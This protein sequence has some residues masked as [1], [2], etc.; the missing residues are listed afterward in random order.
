MN[1][2]G[3]KATVL[4]LLCLSL[5][6][7]A[8]NTHN[9]SYFPYLLPFGD[10]VQTHAKAPGAGYYANFDPYAV[11]LEVRPM[12]DSNGQDITNQARTQHVLIA[13]VYDEKGQPRRDRRVEWMIEGAGHILEVDESGYLS[14]R[15]YK[16]NDK[17]GVSYTSKHENRI[18]RGDKQS[19]NDFM[20]RPGQTWCVLSSAIEGDTHVTVYAPGIADWDKNKVYTTIRWVDAI[21]EFPQPVQKP[22]GSEHVFVTKLA[23]A[24]T[25]QPLAGYRVRY[26]IKDGPAAYFL[27][28]KTQEF[29][30]T[31]DLSGNAEGRITLVRLGEQLPAAGINNVDI[32]V[33]RPPD[34]TAPSGSGI[35]IARGVTSVEW[36]APN[37]VLAYTGPAAALVDEEVTYTATLQNLGK[38]ASEGITLTA[39]VPRGMEFVRSVPP[40]MGNVMGEMLFTLGSLPPGGQPANV[41]LTFKA[42]ELGQTSSV[43]TMRSGGQSDRKEV[44][45][46]IADSKISVAV[47]G[48][49]RVAVGQTVPIN[50]RVTNT[51]GG[52]LNAI[53]LKADLKGGIVEPNSNATTL[54]QPLKNPLGPGQTYTDVLNVV[55]KAKGRAEVQVFATTGTVSSSASHAFDITEPTVSLQVDGPTKKYVGRDATFTIRVT[56]PSDAALNNVMVRNQLPPELDFVTA[57]S[58]Q[59]SGR[60]VVWNLGSL[61]PGQSRDLKLVAR[62][63]EKTPR[64]EQRFVVTSDNAGPANQSLNTEIFGS[65]GLRL[66]MRDLEDPVPVGGKAVYE[67]VI[68]NTGTDEA[69]NVSMQGE[70]AG[71]LAQILEG[72]GP[73]QININANKFGFQAINMKPNETAKYRVIVL[74]GDREMD[75]VFRCILNADV[76]QGP[77]IEDENTRIYIPRPGGANPPPPPPGGVPPGGPF[78]NVSI[79]NGLTPPP[80]NTL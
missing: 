43:L 35:V 40:P 7:S 5:C 76:L 8:C 20:I 51:G 73:S 63:R 57:E 72:A 46:N 15:G 67:I 24:T 13:T 3:R 58:G 61:A 31:S 45:T 28:D 12:K 6:A 9:P 22:A 74:A 10:I 62:C 53:Q 80:A 52:V 65:P 34:P 11:R 60:D 4:L 25:K 26:R 37:V 16:T 1:G 44:V 27:P 78:G 30:A 68:T 19:Q 54:S 56:N 14:G 47:D 32:E 21:W 55:A 18:T 36:L 75:G 39:P 17:H 49:Q 42:K 23:R 77:V 50:I 33:I 64:A 48:P 59:L 29:V 2:L 66:E 70:I 79:N 71:G 69:K 38:V 41:Q